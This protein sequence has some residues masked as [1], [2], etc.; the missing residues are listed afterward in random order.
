MRVAFDVKGT[1]DGPNSQK[2][3][4]LLQTLESKGC[5]ITIWS[6]WLPFASELVSN[7]RLNFKYQSKE[8]RG[9]VPLNE[10]FDVAVEDDTQQDFLAAKRFVFVKDIPEENSA[11]VDLADELV[12]FAE[13]QR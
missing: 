13:Q 9:D 3:W 10:W 5:D 11:I 8:L 2:V 4:K 12:L 7:R 6:S 1:L